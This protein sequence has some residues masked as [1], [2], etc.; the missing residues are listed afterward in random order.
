[1]L[2]SYCLPCHSRTEDLRQ[3]LPFVLEAANIACG[4]EIVIV[5]YANAMPLRPMVDEIVQSVGMISYDCDGPTCRVIQRG[6][7]SYFHMAH[8]RNVGIRA[9]TGDYAVIGSADLC[10]H[11]DLFAE[12]RR[13][14]LLT[15]ATWLIPDGK[16]R[17]FLVCQRDALIAAGGYDERF[18]FY[19]PEDKDLEA[20]LRRRLGMPDTYPSS[21]LSVIETP[22]A[23]K[24][25]GYRLPLSKSE[26]HALGKAV[27]SDN[28]ARAALTVN[29]GVAWGQ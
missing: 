4:V 13:R 23:V 22:D 24:T 8:A 19:G 5:D 12:I 16:Y 6:G 2:L 1:M 29:E 9:S 20:R 17:G 14:L 28:E 21:L 15:D 7:R 27:L 25:Q 3:A 11:P 10:P 26:M 18:E